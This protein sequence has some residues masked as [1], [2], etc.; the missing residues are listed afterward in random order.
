MHLKEFTQL[1]N[2]HLESKCSHQWFYSESGLNVEKSSK[3]TTDNTNGTILVHATNQNTASVCA[4]QN[5]IRHRIV[6]WFS[7]NNNRDP[8]RSLK[9]SYVGLQRNRD[10]NMPQ[11]SSYACSTS[12]GKDTISKLSLLLKK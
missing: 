1:S 3:S 10:S 6:C 2:L 7:S 12:S 11:C 4:F 8:S 5:I 9:V